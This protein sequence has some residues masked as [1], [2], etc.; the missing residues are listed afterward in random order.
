MKRR[1]GMQRAVGTDIG[2]FLKSD[3]VEDA[4]AIFKTCEIEKGRGAEKSTVFSAKE[5][6]IGKVH[7][8]FVGDKVFMGLTA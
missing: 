5:I 4:F 2:P 1:W 3:F 7:E 6:R 8:G